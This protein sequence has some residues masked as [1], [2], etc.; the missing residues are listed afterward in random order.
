M[1]AILQ[2]ADDKNP[3]RHVDY[4]I[5]ELIKRQREDYGTE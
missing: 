5:G 4:V 3:L 2:R 1:M